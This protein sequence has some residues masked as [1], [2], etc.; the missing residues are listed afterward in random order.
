MKNKINKDQQNER[1][2]VGAKFAAVLVVLILLAHA[3]YN[4]VPVAYDGES[5]K[6]EM[7]TAVVQ[8]LALPNGGKPLEATKARLLRVAAQSNI[9]EDAMIDVKMIKTV[10]QAHVS[11]SKQVN[12]LP[13]GLYTYTYHFDHTATPTGFLLK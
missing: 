8:G 7:Q 4:Y 10:I 2:S 11:Y 12:I 13:F 1:G 6:Q 3:G 5:F 9:P